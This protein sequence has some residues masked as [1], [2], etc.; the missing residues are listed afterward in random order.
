MIDG[1]K[2]S[3]ND[4]LAI[5]FLN[6]KTYENEREY[7]MHAEDMMK[8]GHGTLMTALGRIPASD[9]DVKKACGYWSV[10]DIIVHLTA[11]EYLL[12]DALNSLLGETETPHIDKFV[13]QSSDYN[14]RP[15]T[16][17]QEKSYDQ[18]LGDYQEAY[19]ISCERLALIDKELYRQSGLL[20]WYG[21]AY[22]LEDFIVYTIYAHKR[23]HS[24]HIDVFADTIT[25]G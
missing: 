15:V 21:E 25:N 1:H 7:I 13:N 22:D 5:Q 20:K 24:A 14:D 3:F 9:I 10:K 4:Y 19:E 8:Y 17:A 11:S 12:N 23:E 6:L 18:V 2:V 16:L